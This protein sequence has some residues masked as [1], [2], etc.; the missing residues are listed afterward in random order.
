MYLFNRTRSARPEKFTEAM[1]WAVQIAE[2]A[3]S[4]LGTKVSVW[5]TVLSPDIS[6]LSWTCAFDTLADW[7]DRSAGLAADQDYASSVTAAA[8]LFHGPVS[9]SMSGLI[10]GMSGNPEANNF[11]AVV[12]ATAAS[13]HLAGAVQHGAALAAAATAT[14]GLNTVFGSS[15]TGNYGGV[16][17]LTGAPTMAEL[18][19]SMNK[20]NA[21][22]AFVALVDSG[23]A[24]FQPNAT[25]SLH[26]RI[27]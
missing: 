20:T 27:S 4:I 16:I 1:T 21:D 19:A 9:D 11:V 13:G 6:T 23:A 8:P 12:R 7:A 5:G 25:Q 3:S 24:N 15:V 14:G 18:E 22:P 26:Y 10:S 17:W 2:K